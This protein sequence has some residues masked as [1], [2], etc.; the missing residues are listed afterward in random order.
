MWLR[1]LEEQEKTIKTANVSQNNFLPYSYEMIIRP[2]SP[3]YPA[4]YILG[5]Y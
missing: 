1:K 2:P 3:A 4:S 5:R